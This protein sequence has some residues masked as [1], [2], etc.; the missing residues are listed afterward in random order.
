MAEL[1]EENYRGEDGPCRSQKVG[2]KSLQRNFLRRCAHSRYRATSVGPKRQYGTPI[3]RG[4]T[5]MRRVLDPNNLAMGADWFAIAV[6]ITLPWS[7][8]GTAVFIVLW[9]VTLIGSW[10]F[11]DRCSEPW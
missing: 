9:L 4:L 7:T 5:V 8:T 6:A 2:Q 11:A 1:T 3:S 10:S